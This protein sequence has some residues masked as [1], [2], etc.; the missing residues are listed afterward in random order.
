MT[1]K[2]K[3]LHG[4]VASTLSTVETYGP[5]Q[6]CMNLDGADLIILCVIAC[7]NLALA[8]PSLQLSYIMLQSWAA[9]LN[10]IMLIIDV[11]LRLDLVLGSMAL[12]VL[13]FTLEPY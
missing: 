6:W 9:N 12:C 3:H 5:I 13:Y 10:V 1:I 7:I 4:H 11:V 2:N 8:L